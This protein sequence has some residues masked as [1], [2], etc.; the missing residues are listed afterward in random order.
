MTGAFETARS[1]RRLGW[2]ALALAVSCGSDEVAPSGRS[3]STPTQ[4]VARERNEAP[5]VEAVSFEPREPQAGRELH[6]QVQTVD[7]DGDSVR[8]RF[9]WSVDG[10][11]VP[12]RG[13]SLVVPL[14]ARKDVPVEVEV[15]ASDGVTEAEPFFARTR[16]GNRPPAVA[17]VRLEP[18][19]AVRVG[20]ELV[21]L[22]EAHDPDDDPLDLRY[23][24]R[25]NGK[26]VDHDGERFPTTGLRR[27]DR[28]QVR[29]YASDG[30]VE[31]AP[32]ESFPVPVGNAAPAITSTPSA[33]SADGVLRYAVQVSDPDGDR[34]LRFR[35]GE[36]PAGAHIDPVLGE[37]T[38]KASRE[39]VG[40]HPIEVVVEDGHG[41][42]TSQRFEVTVRETVEK[43]SAQPPAA[44]E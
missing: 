12:G 18:A 22:P 39:Q 32:A 27:G 2:I 35:L 13:A 19:D 30:R 3:M 33:V 31:S 21:A 41:G 7:P 26:A 43:A 42:K 38:W 36:A 8:L 9:R 1:L 34:R 5:R 15:V 6:A 20:Q 25:V 14:E 10:R 11:S 4:A 28:I 44:A 16:V 40:V 17:A 23:E 24:W 29:A 37:L